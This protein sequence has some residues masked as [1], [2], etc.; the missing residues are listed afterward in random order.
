[1]LDEFVHLFEKNCPTAKIGKEI[2]ND[3]AAATNGQGGGVV[4]TAAPKA[5]KGGRPVCFII[6]P[7]TERQ[8]DHQVGFFTEVLEQLFNPA[9]E[10][11]GFEPRT[12]L[13]QGSDVIQATIVN[14]LL[15]AD[16]VLADL[17][18]HNPNVLFELGMRMHLD[19]P[20]AL[21]RAKG[22]GRVFDVDN[23]LRVVDYDPNVWPSTVAKDLP[24][25]TEHV[26]ATWDNRS[27]AKTFMQILA[28]SPTAAPV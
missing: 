16:M 12:A 6:M 19:K 13:R 17:T 8:D 25:I 22:T 20:V 28:E 26:K 14:A 10:A 15:D 5:K 3:S 27:K 24:M 9:L 23:M 21:V 1:M 11:A 4:S 2:P 7:F 18:E